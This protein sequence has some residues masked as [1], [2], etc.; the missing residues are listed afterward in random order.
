MPIIF[1]K[2]L[3]D[4]LFAEAKIIDLLATDKSIYFA[5]PRP[6]IVNYHTFCSAQTLIKL[7]DVISVSMNFADFK[8]YN[9]FKLYLEFIWE[10][11]EGGRNPPPLGSEKIQKSPV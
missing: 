7:P 2:C 4:Q 10:V 3:A 6:I 5:Q 9:F 11:T 1:Q 8:R